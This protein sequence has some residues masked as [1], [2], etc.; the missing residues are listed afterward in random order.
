MKHLLTL[1]ITTAFASHA[2]ADTIVF[3]FED[4]KKVNNVLFLLDAPLEQISGSANGV[5]GTV[6]GHPDN[7]AEVQGKIVVDA[8]SLHVPNPVM[9]EHLHG[10]DWLDSAKHPE[11]SFELKSVSNVK[12]DG[13]K[14]TADATG[15]FTMRGISKEITV[16]VSAHYLPGRLKERG[17]DVDGDILVLRSQ[18]TVK[19][20]D[21]GIKPGEFEDKVSDDIQVTLSVAGIAPKS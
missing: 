13:D 20:S 3:N 15:I 9:K 7:P 21:F 5:S 17:G 4:P 2:F 11:I 10:P 8:A 18:F 12:K 6:T 19:R 16:P 14:G 1:A